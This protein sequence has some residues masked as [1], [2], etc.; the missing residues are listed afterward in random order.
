MHKLQIVWNDHVIVSVNTSAALPWPES[1]REKQQQNQKIQIREWCDSV[2]QSREVALGCVVVNEVLQ[3]CVW[4]LVIIT[5]K[6]K[7]WAERSHQMYLQEK[8][9]N[10]LL[11]GQ[12]R[13]IGQG[14]S[15]FV[16]SSTMHELIL[17][18]ESLWKMRLK[19]ET[20]LLCEMHNWILVRSTII[21]CGECVEIE[22]RA[23]DCGGKTLYW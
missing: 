15:F 22:P 7:I 10:I 3:C 2:G 4:H 13:Q 8:L 20:R 16:Q 6:R 5:G 19:R 12:T 14:T 9:I 23:A 11:C 18:K 17:Q 21:R 1:C